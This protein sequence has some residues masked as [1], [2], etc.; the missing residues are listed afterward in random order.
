[1]STEKQRRW[2]RVKAEG[3]YLRLLVE[4]PVRVRDI[5]AGGALLE[6]SA[7]IAAGDEARLHTQIQGRP[8]A[9]SVVV[10]RRADSGP[11]TSPAHLA[12][13]FGSM[14]DAERKALTEFLKTAVEPAS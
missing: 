1:M 12:V 11:D 13:A 8:F 7:P 3:C 9:P 5:G 6:A 14:D 10:A 4:V 2:P